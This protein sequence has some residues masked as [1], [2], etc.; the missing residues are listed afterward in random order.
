MIAWSGSFGS[1][2]IPLGYRRGCAAVSIRV[3][4]TSPAFATL[5]FCEM[6]I[7]PRRVPTHIVFW[8]SPR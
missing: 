3:Y 8:S 2:E 4:V 1:I 7:R 5:A 6:K